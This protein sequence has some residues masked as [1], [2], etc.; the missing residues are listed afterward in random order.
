MTFSEDLIDWAP[1]KWPTLRS[2]LLRE[3]V[4]N[5]TIVLDGGGDKE[6]LSLLCCRGGD[7]RS[8]GWRLRR[9]VVTQLVFSFFRVDGHVVHR[10]NTRNVGKVRQNDTLVLRVQDHLSGMIARTAMS[11]SDPSNRYLIAPC[12]MLQPVHVGTSRQDWLVVAGYT[13]SH[14]TN[15]GHL[16]CRRSLVF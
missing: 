8:R 6:E 9:G 12:H 13:C 10:R 4:D 14:N 16:S 15:Q 3:R 2:E 11:H 1:G 7:S 5:Q